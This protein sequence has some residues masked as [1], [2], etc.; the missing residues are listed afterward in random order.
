[1]PSMPRIKGRGKKI[2]YKVLGVPAN[3]VYKPSRFERWINHRLVFE[4][5]FRVR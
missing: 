1:M 3:I 2:A 4:E 5:T